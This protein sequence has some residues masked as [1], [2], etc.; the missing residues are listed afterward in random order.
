MKVADRRTVSHCRMSGRTV[1][2]AL[3]SILL[4]DLLEVLL[5]VAYGQTY[6]VTVGGMGGKLVS[7]T[8]LISSRGIALTAS[9]TS[10]P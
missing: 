8:L 1:V 3:N 7:E 4:T 9:V 6:L 5:E 2:F 10:C